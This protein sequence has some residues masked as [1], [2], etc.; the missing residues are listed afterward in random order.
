MIEWIIQFDQHLFLR[1][2]GLHSPFFDFFM[3]WM[4]DKFIW[5]PLY[6][7]L[8]FLMIKENRNKAWL[9]VLMIVLLVLLTDQLSVRLFKDVFHRLR[10]CHEPALEGM[11]RTL[12]GHCGGQYGFISSHACNTAGIAVFAGLMLRSRKWLFPLLLS[13]SIT[14]S[15]SRIYLGVHYPGDVITGMLFGAALGYLIYRLFILIKKKW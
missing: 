3:F 12:F 13:W 5:I 8:L 1:L 4:S 11:V 7:W 9:V 15:Y 6:A 2:N 10:P 14:I